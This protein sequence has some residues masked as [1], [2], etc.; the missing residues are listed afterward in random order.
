MGHWNTRLHRWGL[1]SLLNYFDKSVENYPPF[2]ITIIFL[3]CIHYFDKTVHNYFANV[4]QM[5]PRPITWSCPWLSDARWMSQP[6]ACQYHK[7]WETKRCGKKSCRNNKIHTFS[8]KAFTYC[9]H[10]QERIKSKLMSVH[11]L[12]QWKPSCGFPPALA[13]MQLELLW[14]TV[15]VL[16]TPYLLPLNTATDSHVAVSSFSS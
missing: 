13:S 5:S 3:Y 2:L 6:S 10:N 14:L 4:Y 9:C 8:M 11:N 16:S 1:L 15:S 7:L 12:Y